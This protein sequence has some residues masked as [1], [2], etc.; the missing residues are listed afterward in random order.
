MSTR[1]H[2]RVLNAA[3]F[4][5][6]LSLTC[7]Q[8]KGSPIFKDNDFIQMKESILIGEEARRELF[9]LLEAD[10]QVSSAVIEADM[11]PLVL[12]IVFRILSLSLPEVA[13]KP[14]PDGLQLVGGYP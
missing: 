1:T 7:Y 6:L 12:G 9:K 8:A 10:V 11:S 2:T 13:A 4:F 5:P 3:N 14:Q